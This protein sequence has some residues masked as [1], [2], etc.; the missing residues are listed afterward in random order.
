MVMGYVNYNNNRFEWVGKYEERHIPKQA[1]W[2]WDPQNKVWYTSIPD[3][4]AKLK[5]Y[6][7]IDAA[8]AYNQ[9]VEA[10]KR[11]EELSR[12]V[13]ANFNV[14]AP[15]GKDYFPFQKAG[16]KFAV[17][18]F[19]EH[20]GALIADEMGTGKTIQSA[21]VI[22]VLNPDRVLV[23]CPASLKYNW[24]R[25]LK[26]WLVHPKDVIVVNGDD[27]DFSLNAIYIINYDILHRIPEENYQYNL[28][29][30]DECH[31]IKNPKA[32]R[33]KL[34]KSITKTSV[35]RGGK[36]LFLTGTP[37]VNRPIELYPILELAAPS[38]FGNFWSYA[39]RYCNAHYNG[40]GWDFRG[41]S[42]LEELQ[43]RLRSSIM[44]RRLKKDVL[45]E[46]PPKMR[47]VVPLKIERFVGEEEIVQLLNESL[48]LRE[49][50]KVLREVAKE[51][52]GNE[53]L[54]EVM[55]VFDEK[56]KVV[57]ERVAEMRKFYALQK[58]PF[59]AT[60][61]V[62]MLKDED[63]DCVVVFA[64]HHDV[65][66]VLEGVFE[67]AGISYVKITG[68]ESAEGRQRAVETF[69]SGGAQVALCSIIAAGVGITLTRARTAVF[70]E[71]D[72]VPGNILQAED[73]LHRIGQEAECVDIHYIVARYTLD[74]NF[75]DYLTRK[76]EII[77]KALNHE[78]MKTQLEKP[79]YLLDVITTSE[80][81]RGEEEE[82]KTVSEEERGYAL[83]LQQKLA[84]VA[85][86]DKDR[87]A[88]SNNVGFNRFD[89][90][91]GH[92]LVEIPVEKW[93]NKMLRVAEK[94]VNKY[95]KQIYEGG[96]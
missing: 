38:A 39:K 27:V 93:S 62:D 2:R 7:N 48:Q 45:K 59:A 78:Y 36:V 9:M 95:R 5:D 30:V 19:K 40:Y 96:V 29:I 41:A 74:E 46:L 51:G 34:V 75:A 91:I 24:E 4:A 8:K 54:A 94:L 28:I 84:I 64:H 63:T 35:K 68:K 23:I 49:Y 71:L 42:N 43:Q 70:V 17:E 60:Y 31:Y 73:R 52:R 10:R 33:S 80:Q 6:F 15:A 32:R 89:T 77:E 22:N 81:Q 76:I 11:R 82:S 56:M 69:Q 53:E 58:A 25:E 92:F 87:A 90:R 13:S 1:G 67:R 61:I 3:Y 55:Q 20:K 86:L 88:Q 83:E 26:R 44:I 85:A 12:A 66:G 65:F 14:P 37:I 16:V 57:F 50:I 47:K 21:G 18:V 72:W 79:V